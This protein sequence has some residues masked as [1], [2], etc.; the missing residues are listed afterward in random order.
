VHEQKGFVIATVIA[1]AIAVAIACLDFAHIASAQ[2]DAAEQAREG[3]IEHWI[4]YY[5]AEQR[6]RSATPPREPADRTAPAEKS[7]PAT[8]LPEKVEHK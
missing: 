4:E 7:A 8:S 1:A 3:G 5:K 2:K 6:K